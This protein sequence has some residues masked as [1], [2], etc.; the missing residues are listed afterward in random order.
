M[1]LNAYTI[2]DVASGTY[3]RPFFAQADGMAVRS[4]KD[5]ANDPQ[6]DIGAHP[7]DYTLFRVGDFNER[8]GSLRGEGL[9]KLA[10][11]LEM[12]SQEMNEPQLK[13]VTNG[14]N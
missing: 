10:T 4:F 14:T 6:H 7:E 9:E 12:V 1:K 5:I 11:G 13:E 3:M 8:T 2:Y